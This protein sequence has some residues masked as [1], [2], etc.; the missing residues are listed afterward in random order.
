MGR[1]DMKVAVTA[2]GQEINGP[3][4]P[5]FGRAPYIIIVD[6]ETMEYEAL[7]NQKNV[8]A[9]KGAGIQAATI[10]SQKGVEVLMTGYCGPNAF[11]TLEAGGVKVVQDVSGTVVE[12]VKALVAGDVAYSE[13]PNKE[14][15]W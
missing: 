12:A 7:D 15:H 5:R 6:S 2:S 11:K 1:V 3:V 14:G 13:A 10:I 4:D 8:Q 9:F